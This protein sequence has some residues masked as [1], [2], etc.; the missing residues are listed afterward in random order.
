MN[1]GKKKEEK[2]MSASAQPPSPES[3]RVIADKPRRRWVKVDVDEETFVSLHLKAAESRMRI[4]PYLRRCLAEVQAYGPGK[5][6]AIPFSTDHQDR[7]R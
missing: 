6:P 5:E 3:N 2:I 4:Q 7:P 1:S